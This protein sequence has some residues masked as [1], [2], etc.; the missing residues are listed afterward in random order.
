MAASTCVLRPHREEQPFGRIEPRRA[1][2]RRFAMLEHP[3]RGRSVAGRQRRIARGSPSRRSHASPSAG[4]AA[5]HCIRT[6]RRSRR[7]RR[8][9][10]PRPSEQDSSCRAKPAM[11]ALRAALAAAIRAWVRIR[12]ASWLVD[13]C[14]REQHH[15]RHQV[16]RAVDPE[17]VDRGGEE[18]IVGERRSG[19]GEQGRAKPVKACRGQHRDEVEQ[20]DRPTVPQ[21]GAISRPSAGRRRRP[22]P[23]ISAYAR[24]SIG[25]ERASRRRF[26]AGSMSHGAAVAP[27]RRRASSA[28]AARSLRYANGAGRF[29]HGIFTR[30][31]RAQRCR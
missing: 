21:S 12:A 15:D 28:V 14:D 9:R 25:K 31:R 13:Q 4:R 22:S 29:P 24:A 30:P 1:A 18:E 23:A 2:A 10:S 20:V 16:G 27:G 3:G 5:R 7:R 26:A 11:V 6:A 17:A 8:R 19:R